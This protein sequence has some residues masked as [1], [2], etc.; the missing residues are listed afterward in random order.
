MRGTSRVTNKIGR[1][2]L[3]IVVLLLIGGG[4]LSLHFWEQRQQ[5]RELAQ[6]DEEPVYEE[7]RVTVYYEDQ[8]YAQ[9]QDVQTYLLLGLDK[10]ED[11]LSDPEFF[12]NNQQADFLLLLIVDEK[13]QSYRALHI[14]RDTMVE[15]QELGPGGVPI[16]YYEAQ[17]A[18][19]H[20]YGSGGK[21]SCRNS[22]LAVSNYLYG[23]SIDH[24]L[25]ITMDAIPILN[26]LVGGVVVHVE[27]DFSA[28]DPAI[29]KGEDVRL[30]GKQALTFVR[31]RRSME[32]ST[33]LRRMTRQREYLNGLYTQMSAKMQSSES[34]ALKA[35]MSISDYLVS[36][37]GASEL[38][39]LANRL[40]DYAYLG[41]DTI[42]GEAVKGNKY[43][44]FYPDEEALQAQVIQLFF[45]ETEIE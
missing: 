38:S 4:L 40:K 12:L 9:R 19:S 13:D 30:Q 27:D 31:A 1:P 2:A 37:C 39:D 33:N 32:D 15:V 36:D 16:G 25:S 22:V 3:I 45:E 42:E 8:W 17:I 21:D 6:I 5:Q 29:K 11:T 24:Y 7:E 14:N 18:L 28:L 34:F 26:D 20:I 43:M 23:I 44:E 41:I 10:F 35:V